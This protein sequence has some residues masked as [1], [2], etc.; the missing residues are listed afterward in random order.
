MVL[1]QPRV[2]GQPSRLYNICP[3]RNLRWGKGG[4]DGNWEKDTVRS[5]MDIVQRRV[6]KWAGP[7]LPADDRRCVRMTLKRCCFPG[8]GVPL[9]MEEQQK[10][11]GSQ[12]GEDKEEKA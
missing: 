11:G 6:T 7:V 10:T 8:H 3:R 12:G 5:T 1:G 4:P 2:L 9:M